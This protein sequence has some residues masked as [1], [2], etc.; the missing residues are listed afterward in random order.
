MV[1]IGYFNEDGVLNTQTL[2]PITKEEV[3][4]GETISITISE[5]EQLAEIGSPWKQLDITDPPEMS[6]DENQIIT[7]ELYD[8]GDKIAFKYEVILDVCK[9]K[10]KIKSKKQ[11]L[12]DS[13]YKW[14]KIG[15]AQFKGEPLPYDV[16]EVISD[17]EALRTEIN[18]LEEILNN[19]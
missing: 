14:R 18:N 9:I 10:N 3:F 1:I 17:A 8:N 4:E 19:D 11:Q 2:N 12:T 7:K 6:C 5:V 16:N 15:E 13:D